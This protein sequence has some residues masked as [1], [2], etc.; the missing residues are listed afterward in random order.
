[1]R[2]LSCLALKT[3]IKKVRGISRT[4]FTNK[5]CSPSISS[6]C[7]LA[8][9]LNLTLILL[10]TRYK[11]HAAKTPRPKCKTM[12]TLSLTLIQLCCQSCSLARSLARLFPSIA[13]SLPLAL[14]LAAAAA[15]SLFPFLPYIRN[16]EETKMKHDLPKEAVWLQEALHFTPRSTKMPQAPTRMGVVCN[17]DHTATQRV[18]YV[19]QISTKCAPKTITSL[20][21][22]FSSSPSC[23]HPPYP[24]CPSPYLLL[25]RLHWGSVPRAL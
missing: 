4:L 9:V 17:V 25:P 18:R 23:P 21:L 7:Q 6:W 24:P 2:A 20:R 19:V 15:V 12:R 13:L 1:M 5:A 11:L 22:I 3:K 8:Q 14:S 16:E 10:P